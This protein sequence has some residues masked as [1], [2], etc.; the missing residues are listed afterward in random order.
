MQDS[1]SL[2]D[3]GPGSAPSHA[4]DPARI[5]I[6]DAGMC[7]GD[8]QVFRRINFSVGNEESVTILG[9]SGCG[10]TTLLRCIAG[11]VP[12]AEGGIF[13]E[14]ERIDNPRPGMAMV[15]QN[16]GLFPWKNTYQNIAYGLRMAGVDKA[17]IHTRVI[18]HMKMVGLEGFEKAYPHQLS[19]GMQQRCG[20]ARA[21]AL[22]PNVILMDEPF[23]SIDAQTRDILQFEVLRIWS[24]KPTTMVFVTHSVEEAILMGHRVVVLNGRPS[25]V[26]EIVEVDLPWPRTRETLANP[27]FSELREYAWSLIG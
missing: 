8:R 25:S 15:F 26:K 3:Q 7:Y 18:E 16:F 6:A 10:K 19:G 23:A 14:G 4:E 5:R 1:Q 22:K 20:L 17:E 21:L 9:P 13:I 27:R 12:V 11:L 2:P 24:S